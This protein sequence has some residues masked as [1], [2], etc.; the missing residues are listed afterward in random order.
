MKKEV[1]HWKQWSE[2]TKTILVVLPDPDREWQ[3]KSSWVANEKIK[4]S[5]RKRVKYINSSIYQRTNERRKER[6]ETSESTIVHNGHL[7]CHVTLHINQ[8]QYRQRQRQ[9]QSN[10]CTTMAPTGARDAHP[11]I[12]SQLTNRLRVCKGNCHLHHWHNT[13]DD[14]PSR[15]PLS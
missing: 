7:T 5:E 9:Q 2:S 4:E 11:G 13:R 12:F 15:P 3:E 14:E 6:N 1:T 8:R 10:N